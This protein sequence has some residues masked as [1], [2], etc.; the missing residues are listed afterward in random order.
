M[1]GDFVMIKNILI[2]TVLSIFLHS[3]VTMSTGPAPP[4]EVVVKV[5]A[6]DPAKVEVSNVDKIHNSIST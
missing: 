1:G 6:A 4:Q 3:C 5:R 2:V